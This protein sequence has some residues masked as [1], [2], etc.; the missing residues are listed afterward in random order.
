MT[1]RPLLTAAVL[2]LSACVVPSGGDGGSGGGAATGGGGAATGGGAGGGSASGPTWY[3]DVLPVVQA[4]CLGCHVNGGIAPFP[5]DSYAAASAMS[6]AMADAVVNKRMPPWLA[7]ESCAGPYRDSRALSAA[8]IQV[9]DAWAQ[10]GAPEGNPAD[11]P[12]PL[13]GTGDALPRV[14]ATLQMP[15]AYTPSATLTDDYRCF[16]VDPAVAG[17]TVVA[18][19]DILPGNKTVV[20]HVI[21]YVVKRAAAQ[22]KDAE[23]TTAGWQCFGGADVTTSATLG[24]WAPGGSAVVY[25]ANTGIRIQ[26]D[27]VLAMQVHYNTANGRAPDQTSMK[28]MYGTGTETNAY[29]LPLVASGFS[30]PANAVDYSYSRAF[31]NQFG[32]PIKLYGFLPHM[33]TKGKKISLRGGA[34]NDCLVDIPRWDFHWQTQYFRQSPYTLAAGQSLTMSCTWDNPTGT[35]VTWGEGTDDEMCFAYVYATP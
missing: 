32:I 30:I 7:D 14:D 16:I 26:P 28:L 21:V 6:G 20:H 1:L 35:R 31:P 33:H 34:A 18:G 5:L 19:Y 3:K 15:V 8:E 17:T 9:I 11:A 2:I 23:D 29:L 4:R 10:A 13:M 12:P 24:A 22:T 27:E 25:P